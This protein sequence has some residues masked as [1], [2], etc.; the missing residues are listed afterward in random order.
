[1]KIRKELRLDGV[2]AY[3]IRSW[4]IKKKMVQRKRRTEKQKSR[5]KMGLQ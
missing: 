1:M 5:K 2:K 4:F 3:N